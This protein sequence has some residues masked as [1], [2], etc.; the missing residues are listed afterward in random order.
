MSSNPRLSFGRR[1]V[2]SNAAYRDLSSF[3]SGPIHSNVYGSAQ[4]E[5][6]CRIK[7]LRRVAS[8]DELAGLLGHNPIIQVS[9]LEIVASQGDSFRIAEKQGIIQRTH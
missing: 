1:L 8:P 4:S 7:R 5:T 2:F 6:R 9:V 3:M